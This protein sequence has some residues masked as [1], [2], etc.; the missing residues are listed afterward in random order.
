MGECWLTKEDDL[1]VASE[2][3]G[4]YLDMYEDEALGIYEIDMTYSPNLRVSDWVIELTDYYQNKYGQE[5]GDQIMQ[6]VL[7]ACIVNGESIH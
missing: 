3:I 6:W 7:S 4:K 5:Q 2:I 1:K